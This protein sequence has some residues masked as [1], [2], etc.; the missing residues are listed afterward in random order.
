M[1]NIKI[2]LL[3]LISFSYGQINHPLC[4]KIYNNSLRIHK[5]DFEKK[6]QI[7]KICKDIEIDYAIVNNSDKDYAI[8]IDKSKF[9]LYGGDIKKFISPDI[10]VLK[11]QIFQPAILIKSNNELTNTGFTDE[12]YYFNN[13]ANIRDV[14]NNYIV[15]IK[16]DSEYRIKSKI[17]LPLNNNNIKEGTY[18]QQI[19]LSMVY[20]G[21]TEAKL[22][23]ILKQDS[24]IIEKN[25]NRRVKSRLKKKELY[26]MMG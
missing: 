5:E 16:A 7:E 23:L 4:I 25:L 18:S 17:S 12:G 19:F 24:S 3:F 15:I 9:M 21:L 20:E 1:R 22:S 8:V 14:V 13:L 11:K 26:F 6:I 2:L 10:D